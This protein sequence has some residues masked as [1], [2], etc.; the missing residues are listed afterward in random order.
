MNEQNE[1]QGDLRDEYLEIQEAEYIEA[2]EG[3]PVVELDEADLE[4]WYQGWLAEQDDPASIDPDWYDPRAD[5]G[6]DPRD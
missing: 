3:A 2:N 1:I 6:P 5:F 4:D